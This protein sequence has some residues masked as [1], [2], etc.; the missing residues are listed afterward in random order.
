MNFRVLFLLL[1]MS[2][3][4]NPLSAADWLSGLLGRRQNN[5]TVLLTPTNDRRF[6]RPYESGA[7][8][9]AE[10]D[11][12]DATK[13]FRQAWLRAWA[14][15]DPYLA[16]LASYN[17]AACLVSRDRPH[18]ALDYLVDARAELRRA[19]CSTSN[20]WLLES[21]IFLSLAN[22]PSAARAL[23][24]A[25]RQRPPC[26]CDESIC[27][28]P[29][30]SSVDC[31][32]LQCNRVS[33][34]AACPGDD[35]RCLECLPCVG[36]K[37]RKNRQND[38]CHD[39]HS[40]RLQL[41]SAR[42]A[43]ATGDIPAACQR[44]R[45]A[46]DFL[47]EVCDPSLSADVEDVAAAIELQ[48]GNDAAAVR[49]LDRQVEFLR[50]DQQYREIPKILIQAADIDSRRNEFS[51]AAARYNRA[52]RIYFVRGDL[53]RSWQL[54]QHASQWVRVTPCQTV[55]IRL[56]ITAEE[57]SRA[58]QSKDAYGAD[59]EGLVHDEPTPVTAN[60]TEQDQSP[61]ADE[62][63]NQTDQVSL[64]RLILRSP[65]RIGK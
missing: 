63:D 13:D 11:L 57:V 47:D 40:A 23:M 49:H 62:I 53:N 60:Q 61:I 29:S 30:V 21:R 24:Q 50:Y 25:K 55:A 58:L 42:V 2:Q 36:D 26:D 56:A 4:S 46:A 14:T 64:R 10:G 45:C 52:A 27:N 34:P 41:G 18:R 9:F 8:A 39:S 28:C 17:L 43:L 65:I 7:E 15:D 48:L 59:E 54:I 20:A 31:Q 35:K 38:V 44:L 51:S 5:A 37:I 16:G 19:G 3:W 22:Q 32:C 1:L 12:D 33:V 6:E